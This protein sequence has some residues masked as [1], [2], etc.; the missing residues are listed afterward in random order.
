VLKVVQ[1][2]FKAKNVLESAVCFISTAY[3]ESLL[4]LLADGVP[5][6]G[7]FSHFNIPTSMTMLSSSVLSNVMLRFLDFD[8]SHSSPHSRF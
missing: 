1:L 5:T 3:T 2:M 7:L 4:P 6:S 8:F